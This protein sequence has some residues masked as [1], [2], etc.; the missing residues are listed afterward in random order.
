MQQNRYIMAAVKS[1]DCT[2]NSLREK[3]HPNYRVLRS[4][5]RHIPYAQYHCCRSFTESLAKA[6]PRA[7]PYT[8]S[9]AL[10]RE[11]F[12]PIFTAHDVTGQQSQDPQNTLTNG[13]NAGMLTRN[14]WNTKTRTLR[15]L[16][17]KFFQK[18][19]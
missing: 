16:E 2:P 7:L 18:G 6:S 17:G 11:P 15:K 10:H 5:Y 13:S 19:G 8:E 4:I 1:L 12:H 3:R 14:Q 9:L